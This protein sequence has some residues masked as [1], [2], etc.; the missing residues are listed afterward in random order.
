MKKLVLYFLLILI[1]TTINAQKGLSMGVVG[2]ANS[3]WIINQNNFGTLNTFSQP[4]VRASELSYKFKFSYQFGIQGTYNFT[5]KSG[6]MMQLLYAK[7][8]RNTK[9]T[10]LK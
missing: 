2:G 7:A 8:G 5:Q 4:E 3:I 6:V 10:C 9:M 1:S